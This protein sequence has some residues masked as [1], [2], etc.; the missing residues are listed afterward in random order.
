MRYLKLILVALLLSS[1]GC[2]TFSDT[3]TEDPGLTPTQNS[4]FYDFKDI[5]VPEEMEIQ[6]DKSIISP[7]D[8]GKYGTMVFRGRAEPISLF[9]FFFNNMP[10]DGWSLVTYQKYQRYHMVFTK[11]NRVC[12]IT[13]EESPLW[14]TWLEIKVSPKVAGSTEP[15]YP[16]GT[17][18]LTDPYQTYPSSGSGMGSE[19]TLSQ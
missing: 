14:Y 19:R 1:W 5:R 17:Q 15:A 18:P 7:S 3:T 10:K 11:E 4:F 16:T 13:I 9:D 8:S 12:M 2:A 6:T